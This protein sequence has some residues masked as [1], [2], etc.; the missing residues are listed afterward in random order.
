VDRLPA[1]EAH[2]TAMSQMIEKVSAAVTFR[3]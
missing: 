3:V 1:M 2:L